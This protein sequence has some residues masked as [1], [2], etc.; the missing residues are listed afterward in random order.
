[1]K[2]S[3]RYGLDGLITV[4]VPFEEKNE[5]QQLGHEYGIM[6]ISF[7]APTTTN[8]RLQCILNEAEGFIYY[9][10]LTGVTGARNQLPRELI[11][12]LQML[13]TLTG[14]PICVGF[15]ISKVSQIKKI[16][17]FCDGII[18]GSAIMEVIEKNMH[19]SYL[20]KKVI[21]TTKTLVNA[22]KK[23]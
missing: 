2:D 16:K 4:D 10:S 3:S 14:K 13:K 11:G 19:K 15:G 21:S 17:S 6:N 18:I 9:I 8:D 20:M 22:L 1:M 12:R 23:I 7:I 5:L